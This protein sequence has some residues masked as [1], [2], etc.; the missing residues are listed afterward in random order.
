[1]QASGLRTPVG[2]PLQALVRV[3]GRL[4]AGR[5]LAVELGGIDNAI[6]FRGA[7]QALQEMLGNLRDNAC[8]WA[9]GRVLVNVA[10]EGKSLLFMVDDDG[11]GLSES[12]RENVFRRGVRVD[13]QASGS[14]LGLAIVHDL[15]VLY[16]GGAHAE[17]AP[18]GGLRV[19]L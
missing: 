14:G 2:P 6:A 9:A 4:Y 8:K 12:E 16:G 15:A 1:V 19:V 5:G 3:M 17:S 18:I 11:K 10:A 13:E 7:E